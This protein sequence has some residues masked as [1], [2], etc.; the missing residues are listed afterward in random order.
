MQGFY[1]W[2]LAFVVLTGDSQA[3]SSLLG[4]TAGGKSPSL[5][6]A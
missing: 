4:L 5:V 1:T 2:P 6:L 3:L